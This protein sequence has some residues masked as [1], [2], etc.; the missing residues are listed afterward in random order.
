M[1]KI[2]ILSDTHGM[3]RPEVTEALQGCEMIL[4]GGDINKQ[5]ILDELREIAPV[6]AV[7]GNNDKEWAEYIPQTMTVDVFGLRVFMVHNKKD[8][9]KNLSGIDMVIYGH[10]HK[11]EEKVVDR[12]PYLNPG[13]CGPRRFHQEI[14]LALLYIEENGG[15]RIEKRSIPHE[16]MKSSGYNSL[17]K[18]ENRIPEDIAL[19]LP[20]IM[21]EIDAGKT[22][23]QIAK[24]HGISEELS[25]QIARMYL[26]HPGVDV[27]GIL[28]RIGL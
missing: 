27:D 17:K 23:K 16:E 19:M 10:S 28:Q 1:H 18:D 9:P 15:F 13:S 22:V 11:Y 7:R 4:H 26:T 5:K 2:G 6:H 20:A 8:I 12:I 3:L 25:E 21:K 24:K 14:T